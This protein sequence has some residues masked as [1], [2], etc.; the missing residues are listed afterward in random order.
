VCI[1][2]NYAEHARELNNPIPSEPLLFIKPASAMVA[3]EPKFSIPTD[4]G[5]C[6]VETEITLL[7]GRR[8]QNVSAEEAD[9]AIVGVGLGFDLTLR[10]VQHELKRN[11]HPW[12]RAKSFDG[13]LVLS[14]FID[15][16]SCP[17][18]NDLSLSLDLNGHLQQSG[19]VAQML[20]SPLDLVA[21]ISRSFTLE[22]GDLVLTGTPAGVTALHRGDQ[23][24]ATLCNRWSVRSEVL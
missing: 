13:A 10:D 24:G 18:L 3:M 5:E 8:L 6:H 23:L 14:A 7:I 11:G 12:E 4:Q 15:R 16:K 2:R 9:S 22:P 20:W 21:E 19:S 1:G 17:A